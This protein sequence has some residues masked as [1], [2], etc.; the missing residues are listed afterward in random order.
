M[1]INETTMNEEVVEAA[2]DVVS[3]ASNKGLMIGI[4]ISAAG[5][6]GFLTYVYVAKPLIAKIKEKRSESTCCEVDY[7]FG[8]EDK[9]E[10]N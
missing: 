6:L 7:T 1:E 4:G 10:N 5:V 9:S 3:V 2:E 8:E